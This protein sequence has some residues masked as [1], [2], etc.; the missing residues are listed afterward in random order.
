[1]AFKKGALLLVMRTR[2]PSVTDHWTAISLLRGLISMAKSTHH[3]QKQ[4][5]RRE[6]F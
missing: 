4:Y 1:M 6:W 2:V 3:I 5:I